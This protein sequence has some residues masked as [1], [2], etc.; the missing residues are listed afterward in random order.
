MV[1]YGREITLDRHPRGQQHVC[2]LLRELGWRLHTTALPVGW[3]VQSGGPTT[4]ASSGSTPTPISSPNLL[5]AHGSGGAYRTITWGVAD[6]VSG[7][8]TV[9]GTGNFYSNATDDNFAIFA[10][11]SDSTTLYASSTF[12]ELNFSGGNTLSLNK[13]VAGSPTTLASVA[14]PT[15]STNVWYQISLS[16]NGSSSTA[17]T[18]TCQRLS[19]GDW[20]QPGGTW[21][22][23]T[24]S[25]IT[26]TDSSSPITGSGY[27][28]WS[29]ADH[30]DQVFA[31]D[32]TL[33]TFG[34]AIELT[35]AP[36]TYNL[37]GVNAG[38]QA[39]ATL[40]GA[41]GSYGM[42][43]V[44][45]ALVANVPM[46]GTPVA[47]D[48]T[49]TDANLYHDRQDNDQPGPFLLNGIP[50][51]ETWGNILAGAAGTFDVTGVNAGLY[52]GSVETASLASYSLTGPPADLMPSDLIVA[53]PG[54]YT[55]GRIYASLAAQH[56]VFAAPAAYVLTGIPV[57]L[58]QPA[59]L[60][61]A[62]GS[63]GLTGVSAGL[64]AS[65]AEASSVG[66]YSI[67]GMPANLVFVGESGEV[68]YHVYANGGS[69]P[70][71]YESPIDTTSGLTYTTGALTYPSSWSFGVRA[72][73]TGNGLEETNVDAV[74]SV[75]LN[76]SGIDISNQPPAPAGLRAF[77]LANGTA[78]VEWTVPPSSVAKTPTGFHVYLGPPAIS[79][80]SPVATVPAASVLNN[81]Y[82][83]TLTGLSDGVT[84]TIGVRSF[85]ATAEETNTYTVTVTA[86]ASGPGP[87]QGLVG[88][89]TS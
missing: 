36:G 56:D 86:L 3:N 25:A 23:G 64:L 22:A 7:D 82:I 42:A 10:R 78:R 81:S 28:G 50:A 49:G 76:A 75:T 5:Y 6:G 15:I 37:A 38:L 73:Y 54:I 52:H 65:P 32:W 79:Y 59:T 18:C 33:E 9:V 35:G 21:G 89:A 60:A 30:G 16:C 45:A 62:I 69:G 88:I 87:V 63:Y 29:S 80:V 14:I 27:A 47:Y 31:D 34:G 20:L 17:I 58:Q 43:G 48:V 70:I 12:Y 4:T 46:A 1:E 84:Y 39:A 41:E 40:P 57:L 8:V 77:P 11:S 2:D 55:L 83:T 72:F 24:A 19:D 85:N 51:N 67:L 66:S 68:Q 74:I 61:G 71:N 13:S 53:G 26:H 44:N